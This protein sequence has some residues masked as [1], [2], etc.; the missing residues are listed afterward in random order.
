MP[1]R[2]KKKLDIKKRWYLFWTQTHRI[3]LL[4]NQKTLITM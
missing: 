4:Q 3:G 2:N 1:R